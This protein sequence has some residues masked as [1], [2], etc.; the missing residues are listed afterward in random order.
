MRIRIHYKVEK[1][2]IAYRMGIVSLFKEALKISDEQYFS[3]IYSSNNQMR[4][5]CFAP[6]LVEPVIE[7][8]TI[9]LKK[10]SITVSSSDTEFLL[11]LYNGLNHIQVFNYQGS[12]WRKEKIK[13]LREKEI[14]SS[15]V[16]FKTL[17]P[18]LI[19]DNTGKPL[20]P[21]DHRFQEE[22]N[23]YANLMLQELHGRNLIREIRILNHN[24]KK[25][26]IKEKNQNWDKPGYMYFT[27]YKGLI[28]LEGAREDLQFIYRNGVSR[29]RSQG[30]GLLEIE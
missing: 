6:Y 19:E 16:V 21:Q 13:M 8:E 15:T 4:P 11:H 3:T 18:L 10:M 1:L 30:F 22:F 28:Q 24:L 26:V 17:S 14:S 29:R 25:T 9:K 23:Y 2:P 7:N 27:A 20:S 5:F 12:E